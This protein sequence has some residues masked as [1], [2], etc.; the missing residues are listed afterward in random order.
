MFK[1]IET[2]YEISYAPPWFV[3]AHLKMDYEILY[4]RALTPANDFTEVMVNETNGQ[5]T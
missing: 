1:Q 3:P 5:T 4:L 2:G